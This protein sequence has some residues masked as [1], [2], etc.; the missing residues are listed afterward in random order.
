MTFPAYRRALAAFAALGSV[1]ALTLVVLVPA[2]A[3]AAPACTPGYPSSVSTTTSLRLARNV[4]TYG[5]ANTAFIRVS[6]G[7]GTPGGRVGLRVGSYYRSLVLSGGS[8]AAN[9]PRNL[10]ARHTYVVSASYQGRGCFRPSSDSAFYTVYRSRSSISGLHAR[11]SHGHHAR[12]TGR[13]TASNGGAATG[14]VAVR[15]YFQ[16]HLKKSTSVAL[17]RGRFG[18]SFSGVRSRGVW[19]ARATFSPSGNSSGD[20]ASTSFRVRR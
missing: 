14:T 5:S 3:Q 10:P 6:S 15:L 16:G 9:L 13:V 2:S 17:H 12:V 20:S 11:S 18:A 1:L 7:A 8:A 4:G 19:Q